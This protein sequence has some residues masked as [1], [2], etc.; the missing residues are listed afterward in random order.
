MNIHPVTPAW[1]CMRSACVS[2]TFA[3]ALA[4]LTLA[5]TQPA[6]THPGDAKPADV[7]QTFFLAHV[8]EQR[9]VNDILTDLRNMLPHAHSYAV[10]PDH[11]VTVKGSPDDI[12]EAQRLIA[13][14]D[15]PRK[16]YRLSYT[17]NER[18]GD[19]QIS[20]QRLSLIA[21]SGERTVIKQ[22][23]RVPI[24]TGSVSSDT[25]TPSSQVQYLDVGLN[26]EASVEGAP[27]DLR[28]Q[29]RVEQSGLSDEKSGLGAQDPMIRQTQLETNV[30]LSQN[31]PLLLGSLDI[32]GTTRHEEVTVVA[33]L[34][35]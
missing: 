6:E 14:L 34:I 21:L 32:P 29:T 13:E 31:K 4:P 30:L 3:L 22:G 20:T 19:K 27:D 25:N 2:A 1:R 12:A 16:S 26:I 24:V 7:S 11:A 8:T 15:K 23:S 33:E 10:A 18:D 35:H 5:Q 17:I 28:L 9:E